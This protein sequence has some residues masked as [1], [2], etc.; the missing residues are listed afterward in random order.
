MAPLTEALLASMDTTETPLA[1]QLLS[2]TDNPP[3]ILNV[4]R[5][6]RQ[7]PNETVEV[8]DRVDDPSTRSMTVSEEPSK[9]D[10]VTEVWPLTRA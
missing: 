2:T 6:D 8:I 9:L 5:T 7:E 3:P 4:E 10:P 1:V